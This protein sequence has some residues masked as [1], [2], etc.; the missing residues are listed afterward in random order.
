MKLSIIVPV[1]NMAAGGKLSFCIRSIAAQTCKDFEIIA[2][3]DASTDNSFQMLQKL[4]EEFSEILRIYSLPENRKQG[5]ARNFGM[6]KAKGEWIGF[7]DADDWIA[8]DMYQK[9]LEKAEKSGADV[10]GCNYSICYEQNMQVGVMIQNNNEKQ[11][12]KLNEA[13]YKELVL[14]PGSMVIKIYKREI[15][16]EKELFFPEHI[17]YEDNAMAPLWMLQAKHFERVAEPLYYY[18]QVNTSTVHHVTREKCEDRMTAMDYLLQK[19]KEF[20]LFDTYQEELEYKFA[21]LYL[22]N[23][24]FGFMQEG[25]K[26]AFSFAKKIQK[27]MHMNFPNFQ[28]NRYYQTNTNEEEKRLLSYLMKSPVYFVLYYRMLWAYRKIRK[29][30]KLC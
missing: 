28:N 24:I 23:T 22:K 20:D 26:G 13:K 15:I 18:Y 6:Q 10:V 29:G 21:E 30:R 27:G 3:D 2:V 1:Y 5:G 17:F 14:H 7:V 12:G 11:T 4:Q 8:P 25:L 16:F 9:M 19:M